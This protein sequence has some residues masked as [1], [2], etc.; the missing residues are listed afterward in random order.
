MKTLVETDVRCPLPSK[1]LG[2]GAP[3]TRAIRGAAFVAM[4]LAVPPVWG[5]Y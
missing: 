4:L 1:M 3:K 5:A 2:A